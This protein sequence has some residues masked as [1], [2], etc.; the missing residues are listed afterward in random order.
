MKGTPSNP[1]R[2][3]YLA[4]LLFCLALPPG[5]AA[6]APTAP[7]D[8]L[9]IHP[10][11]L[12]TDA[13]RRLMK[14]GE[15]VRGS[16]RGKQTWKLR[17]PR[18]EYAVIRYD[19]DWRVHWITAFARE[20]GRRVRY[21]DIGNLSLATHTGRHFYTW[22]IPARPG[23]GSWTVVARGGDDRYLDSISISSAMRQ[24]LI[25]VPRTGSHNE[26]QVWKR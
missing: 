4:V 23:A 2:A 1:L 5:A 14:L 20:D 11:M 17:D 12:D 10:G 24:D 8:V 7:T 26:G 19:E 16:D 6:S 9:G 18:F 15:V 22:T 13:Q 25:V 3:L 21:R